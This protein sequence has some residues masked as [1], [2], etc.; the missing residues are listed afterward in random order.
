MSDEDPLQIFARGAD[1]PVIERFDRGDSTA[2]QLR[3]Q[4][5]AVDFELW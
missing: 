5:A 1:H 2:R 4:P 3:H